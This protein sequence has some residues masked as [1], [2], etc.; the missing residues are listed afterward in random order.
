MKH[1]ISFFTLVAI[2]ASVNGSTPDSS[3]NYFKELAENHMYYEDENS[4]EFSIEDIID[5]VLVDGKFYI[6][7]DLFNDDYM[8]I[9][10]QSKEDLDYIMTFYN[11]YWSDKGV[12]D[13]WADTIGESDLFY[14]VDIT[15]DS[16]YHAKLYLSYP[17]YKCPTLT[18]D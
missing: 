11:Y 6:E 18:V 5:I 14:A 17:G 3:A 7:I 15:H 2:V 1:L 13:I 16:I 12:R 4:M 9:E 8:S 10:V